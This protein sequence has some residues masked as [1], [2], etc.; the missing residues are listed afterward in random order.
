MYTLLI[1]DVSI[2]ILFELDYSQETHMDTFFL[3]TCW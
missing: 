3:E 1:Q 2:Y